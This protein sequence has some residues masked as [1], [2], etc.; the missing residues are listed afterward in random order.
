MFGNIP[1]Q[2]SGTFASLN[3]GASGNMYILS[4]MF[5]SSN[6]NIHFAL[7]TSII[8]IYLSYHI[9]MYMYHTCTNM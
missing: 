2:F 7:R 8:V 4:R 6:N 9:S 1:L 5:K 3:N